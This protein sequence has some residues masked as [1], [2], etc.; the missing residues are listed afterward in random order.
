M[1]KEVI[2]V[3]DTVISPNEA[4][5]VNYSGKKPLSILKQAENIMMIGVDVSASAIFN[6]EFK[7]DATDGSFYNKIRADLGFDKF[8]KTHYYIELSGKQDLE[9]G[10]GSISAT[11]YGTLETK[12]PYA[13]S[14]Q[15]ALWSIYFKYFYKN[16]RER[17]RIVSE[18]KI[19]KIKETFQDMC[20]IKPPEE[21]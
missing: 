11:I 6:E 10:Q 21:T 18:K 4:L 17:C 8:S 19:Y 15:K 20:G 14:F 3:S 13:N 16:Y 5:S 7:Y 1:A 9:T 2:E 12:F